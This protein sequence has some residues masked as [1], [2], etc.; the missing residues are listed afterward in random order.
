MNDVSKIV[1]GFLAYLESQKKEDLL[2]EIV[3]CLE[4]RL[5]ALEEKAQVISA[6]PLSAAEK[7]EVCSFLKK[8]FGK[9][10]SLEIEIRPGIIAGLI[11][12][13][14]DFVIDQSLLGRLEAL[15]GE[16]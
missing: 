6:V 13:V 1:D 11:I 8:R 3:K 7:R 12:K 14:K 5:Q 4:K 2:P 15:R 10:F 9:D 16:K